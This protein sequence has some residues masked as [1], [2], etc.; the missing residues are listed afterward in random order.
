MG[1]ASPPGPA[2]LLQVTLLPFIL[3]WETFFPQVTEKSV[4]VLTGC[5]QDRAASTASKSCSECLLR[6]QQMGGREVGACTASA[7]A[8][9]RQGPRVL[10]QHLEDTLAAGA[11]HHNGRTR[12]QGTKQKGWAG[13]KFIPDQ[14]RCSLF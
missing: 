3:C 6:A 1:V 4:S 10:R 14:T 9:V 7:S 12:A 13:T 8:G 5:K 11:L 2:V